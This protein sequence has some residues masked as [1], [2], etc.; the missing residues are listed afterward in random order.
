M[1]TWIRVAEIVKAK[2]LQGG[3]VVHS[4]A[5]LPF[6]LREGL[7]VSFVPPQFDCPRSAKVVSVQP[8]S[9]SANY[10]VQ[11]NAVINRDM[12]EGLIGCSCLVKTED[13][14]SDDLVQDIDPL[15]GYHVFDETYGDLGKVCEVEQHSWQDLLVVEGS[16]GMIYI[17][18]V[19]EFVLE[20]DCDQ[21]I[22]KTKIPIGLIDLACIADTADEEEKNYEN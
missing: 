17:P 9:K 21:H 14:H 22:L 3:L 4:A 16:R 18:H 5:G 12:A 10:V 8:S 15:V 13:I 11:F 20:E 6:L 7:S 1:H 19:E 2:T